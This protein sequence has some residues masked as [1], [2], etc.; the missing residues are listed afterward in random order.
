MSVYLAF[1][2]MSVYL[3]FS[4]MSVYLTFSFMSVY[5]TFSFSLHKMRISHHNAIISQTPRFRRG[6]WSFS[7]NGELEK[8]IK[9][10]SK[11]TGGPKDISPRGA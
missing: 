11:F 1:S 3:A 10:V 7:H 6:T 8:K 4:F 2:F 9:G 5:L